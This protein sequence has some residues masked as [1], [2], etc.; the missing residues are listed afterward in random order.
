MKIRCAWHP[1]YFGIELMMGEK[2]PLD[3]N[4]TT[5]GLCKRCLAIVTKNIYMKC[6]QCGKKGLYKNDHYERCRYC[7][8]KRMLTPVN[9]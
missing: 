8:L 3:N 6:P 1:L 4:D 7:D 2:E 9:D 5:D